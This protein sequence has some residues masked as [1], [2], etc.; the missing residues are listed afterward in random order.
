MGRGS[1]GNTTQ[2]ITAV[3][4]VGGVEIEV[5]RPG[6][7]AVTVHLENEERVALIDWLTRHGEQR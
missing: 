4:R 7:P 5:S 1:V 6:A 2:S 3:T